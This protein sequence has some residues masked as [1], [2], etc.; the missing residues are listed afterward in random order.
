[1]SVQ[2]NTWGHVRIPWRKSA[3]KM[4][5]GAKTYYDNRQ[6]VKNSVDV[7][8]RSLWIKRFCESKW[9][10]DMVGWGKWSKTGD[11]RTRQ[12]IMNVPIE[13]KGYPSFH[14]NLVAI[15]WCCL[16]PGNSNFILTN[17]M[18][19]P[20]AIH[21][22]W[23]GQRDGQMDRERQKERRGQTERNSHISYNTSLFHYFYAHYI[24]YLSL[25]YIQL[26]NTYVRA[27]YH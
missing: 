17:K 22:S 5:R 1:M 27:S 21:L 24:A 11:K 7:E 15:M 6:C 16:P 14:K 3:D 26:R 20:K 25:K 18:I 8:E 4:L 9:D 2:T 23:R 19:Y 13:S 10:D 12:S